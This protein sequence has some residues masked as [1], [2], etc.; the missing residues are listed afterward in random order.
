MTR[1]FTIYFNFKDEETLAYKDLYFV[2]VTANSS[3]DMT[4]I[5]L[6][7]NETSVEE[8]L[9]ENIAIYIS[10]TSKDTIKLVAVA[11]EGFS[12]ICKF[13]IKITNNVNTPKGKSILS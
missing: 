3:L 6:E 8:I 10:G 11:P 7:D 4:Y 2:G 9:I 1:E 13:K 5:P 12:D